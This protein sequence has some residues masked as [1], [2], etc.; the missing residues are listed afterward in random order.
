[1][2][3]SFF[4]IIP[5]MLMIVLS[6]IIPSTG[7]AVE[8]K[9][10]KRV[11]I[12]PFETNTQKDISYIIAGIRSMLYSRIAWE[13]NVHVIRK[14]LTT[15]VLS[16]L[17]QT[18]T[19]QTIKQIGKLTNADYIISG[20]VTEFANA[21]SIDSKVYNLKQGTFLTFFDQAKTIDQVISKTDIVAAKINI[22][23]FDRTTTSYEK[24]KKDN[25]LTEEK[26]RR[27]NPEKMMPARLKTGNKK[28]PWWKIW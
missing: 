20:I 19:Y 12:L 18:A 14:D 2:K 22:K 25:P 13:D 3:R 15:K 16:G 17:N 1:M 5:V 27:M 21:F 10:I 28:E 6:L 26:L 7:N 24:F 9:S 23:T 4:C 11:V 8:G